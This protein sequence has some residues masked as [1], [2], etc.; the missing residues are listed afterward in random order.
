MRLALFTDTYGPDVNGVA[1]TL[2][3]W[4][5]YLKR[6]GIECMVFAPDSAARDSAPGG[7]A[8][9]ERFVSLPFFLYPEC[10]LALPN[11]IH[12]RRALH[13][14]KPTLVHVATPFNLGLC[15]IH[16]ARKYELPL[17]ASYHTHFDRYLPFYNLQWMVKM[18][19]RY[20]DWFHQDCRSIFV[21]SKSTYQDLIQRGWDA[22]RLAVWSRGIDPQV[23]H[24]QVDRSK[25]LA[26]HGIEENPFIVLYVGRLAPEKNVDV[27]LEAYASFQRNICPDSILV[28]AGDGPSADTLKER[29]AKEGIPA[30]FLGFTG[31][32]ALQQWYAAA[33]VF[34]FPS[35]TET[36]GNV[37]LEAMA[38]GTPVL[39]ADSGGVTDSVT[40]GVTGLRCVPGS[41]SSFADGLELLYRNEDLRG[42]LS[43]RGRAH[44]AR[45]SWD[46][47]FDDLLARCHEASLGQSHP[48]RPISGDNF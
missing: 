41:A 29:C 34:L 47:I 12:I 22:R 14:F 40:H 35:P 21:P 18:L 38:C 24:P 37:V 44:S 45:Q 33:D 26:E 11:P 30:R 23:F 15:G 6:R 28:L 27:A 3:R 16:Y 43:V 25:L 46:A 9:V 8:T 1:R 31:T 20:M 7:S 2:G 48:I 4:T 10:R 13:A 42:Q 39:C 36:F 5:D 17:V 19:W 32:E